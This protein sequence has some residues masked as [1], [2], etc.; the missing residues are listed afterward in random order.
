MND[1]W[2]YSF[3]VLCFLV[4]VPMMMTAF[5][6]KEFKFMSKRSVFSFS[7][8][9][10]II[11]LFLVVFV[12]GA[13]S[14]IISPLLPAIRADFQVSVNAGALSI[15]IYALCYACGSPLF[16]PL[17]DR[18]N[19]KTLLEIGISIFLIGSFTCALANNIFEF[20]LFRAVAGLGAALTLPNIWATIGSDFTGAKLNTAM[21]ITM[22]ALSLSSAL[23]LGISLFANTMLITIILLIPL[24]LVQGFGVT[25]LTTYI[26]NVVPNNRSTVM[27]FNSSFLYFGLTLGSLIGGVVYSVFGFSGV[28][29]IAAIGLLLAV[30]ITWRVS[31]RKE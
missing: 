19:R 15:T 4:V 25:A 26:V 17:G 8:L 24:A 20:Y 12:T 14:F 2:Y 31:V 9:L 18:Y 22:S 28:G 13:D 1:T 6:E 10:M 23:V 30:L 21:G 11:G 5:K 3:P 7:E 27:S 29:L 16:G